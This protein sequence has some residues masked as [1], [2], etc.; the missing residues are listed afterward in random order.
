MYAL[1]ESVLQ[2]KGFVMARRGNLVTVMKS[3]DA[4]KLDSVIRKDSDDIQP[5]DIIV[6]T[7]FKLEHI[8]TATAQAML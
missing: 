1:L 5:G 3:T 2:F 6:T 7:V 4:A 8:S